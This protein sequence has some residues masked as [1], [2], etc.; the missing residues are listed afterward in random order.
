MRFSE[1]LGL[2]VKLIILLNPYFGS[3][4]PVSEWLAG[5]TSAK[6]A[7]PEMSEKSFHRDGL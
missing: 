5:L 4:F 3:Q 6:N 7:K 2:D 1:W